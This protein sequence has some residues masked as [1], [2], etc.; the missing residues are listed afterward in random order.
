M[1]CVRLLYARRSLIHTLIYELS[2]EPFECL[3]YCQEKKKKLE[4]ENCVKENFHL[5]WS[6]NEMKIL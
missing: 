5:K 2:F 4:I 3:I 6:S 1:M